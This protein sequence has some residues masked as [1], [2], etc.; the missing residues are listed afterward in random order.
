M[1]ETKSSS[2]STYPFFNGGGEMGRLLLE[3]NWR[4]SPLG[5][6]AEWPTQLKSMTATILA[7]PFPMHITWGNDFLQIYNDG[8]RPILGSQKHPGAISK[9][10]Y[11]SYPEIWEQVGPL[12]HQVMKGESVR[13]T[14]YELTLLRNGYP[15]ICYFDFAYSPIIDE[16]GNIGGVLTN[17]IETTRRKKGETD[18]Q[19]LSEDLN[20]INEELTASNEELIQSNEELLQSKRQLEDT[21]NQLQESDTSLR[22]AVE[23]ADFGIWHIHSVTRD[24]ITTQRLR[25]FFG[26]GHL[27]KITIEQAVQQIREASANMFRR[28]LKMLYT[29]MENMM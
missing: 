26:L 27:E 6:P 24:F 23:A 17:V 20:A 11:E 15:E 21:F 29:I 2:N 16:K 25:D 5:D 18:I 9:P 28:H 3:Y 14:D 22:L 10:I 12:F 13:F 4:D 19:K 1:A 7:S 8:Y